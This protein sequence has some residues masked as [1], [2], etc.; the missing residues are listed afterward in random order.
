MLNDLSGIPVFVAVVESGNFSKA[1]Q[2]LFLTRSAVGKTI[3]R[4]EERLGVDLFKRT[5][6][7]QT[8][9]EE[10]K[11]FYQQSRLALDSIRKAEDEIQQGKVLVKGHLKVSLPVLFGHKCVMPILFS[12]AQTYPELKLDLAFSDQQ[13]NLLEEGVDLAVR[14]GTLADSSFIKARQLGQHGMVLCASPDFLKKYAEPFTLAELSHHPAIGYK[15]GGIIQ[16]WQLKDD[17]G[18]IVDFCPNTI[19][20]T[21]DFTAIAAAACNG[22]G[23]AWLPDWLISR[24]IEL[25]ELQQILPNSACTAFSINLIWPNSTWLPYKTRVV[26]D[27]LVAKLP[28]MI[29]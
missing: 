14:I 7:T 18:N 25:G 29:S 27:E 28:K 26:I 13:I 9:T 6:R 1:A 12:L 20:T 19:L 16:N 21:D 23:L 8:L 24:E 11:I 10:G 15:R 4:L 17:I 22:I 2:N 3:S 5:T